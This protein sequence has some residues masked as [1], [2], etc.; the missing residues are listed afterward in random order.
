MSIGLLDLSNNTKSE[1]VRAWLNSE[2]VIMGQEFEMTFVPSNSFDA[3]F[4]IDRVSRTVPNPRSM[5]RF[6][7]MN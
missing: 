7:N 6:R 3:I 1:E 5:E 4:F 2:Q